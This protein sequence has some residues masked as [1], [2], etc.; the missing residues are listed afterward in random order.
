MEI[1]I[2]SGLWSDIDAA[3]RFIDP[4]SYLINFAGEKTYNLAGDDLLKQGKQNIKERAEIK[5]KYA[6][7]AG[8]P[9]DTNNPVG[10]GRFSKKSIP[11]FRFNP[12]QTNKSIKRKK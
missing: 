6:E 10:S 3:P 7:V 1:D 11:I 5:N 8:E 12:I 9:V 2:L 4:L